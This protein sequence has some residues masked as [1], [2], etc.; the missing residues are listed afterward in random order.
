MKITV[1]ADCKDDYCNYALRGARIEAGCTFEELAKRVGMTPAGIGSYERL[2]CIPD[3]DTA[4]KIAEV[5]GKPVNHLF[6]MELR[7][8]A[9]EIRKKRKGG[10]AKAPYGS[11]LNPWL[12]GDIAERTVTDDRRPED[13]A[14]GRELQDCLNQI[15]GVLDPREQLVVRRVYGIGSVSYSLREIGV[16]I[17]LTKARVGQINADAL[18]KLQKRTK[19]LERL[20]TFLA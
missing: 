15:L 4:R 3:E 16:Q 1:R 6:P 20:R 18:A 12:V 11:R 5:L 8:Y 2:R 14:V 9:K 13:F 7:G 19:N 17:H 10:E